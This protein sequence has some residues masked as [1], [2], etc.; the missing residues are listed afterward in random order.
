VLNE[1]RINPAGLNARVDAW[2]GT[3]SEA[4]AKVI[5]VNDLEVSPGQISRILLR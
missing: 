1:D 3:L 4:G 2:K 5:A